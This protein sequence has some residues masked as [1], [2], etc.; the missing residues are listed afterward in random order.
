MIARRLLDAA[1]HQRSLATSDIV[2]ALQ[3]SAPISRLMKERIDALR[4]WAHQRCRFVDK[5]DDE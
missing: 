2:H 3:E 4:T 5:P 1:A